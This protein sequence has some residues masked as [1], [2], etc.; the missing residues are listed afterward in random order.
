MFYNV[1]LVLKLFLVCG[2]TWWQTLYQWTQLLVL[3]VSSNVICMR[4]SF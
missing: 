1:G 4:G 2:P 3:N